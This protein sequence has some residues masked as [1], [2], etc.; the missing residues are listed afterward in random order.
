MR[1][2]AIS[3]GLYSGA[4]GALPLMAHPQRSAGAGVRSVVAVD[5]R[6]RMIDGVLKQHC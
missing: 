1:G 2:S 4:C 5:F 3:L 6:N